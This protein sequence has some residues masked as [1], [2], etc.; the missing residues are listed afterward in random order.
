M[1]HMIH[2]ALVALKRSFQTDS[3]FE[4]AYLAGAVDI[5][6]LERRM[7]EIDRRDNQRP[8]HLQHSV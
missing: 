5:Y 3:S 7:S 8:F 2:R 4:D 1:K 6:D